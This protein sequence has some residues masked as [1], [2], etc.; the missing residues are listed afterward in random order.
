MSIKIVRHSEIG[1]LI[2]N[3]IIRNRTEQDEHLQKILAKRNYTT[4]AHFIKIK[5]LEHRV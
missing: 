4:W 3:R 2:R 5:K 1:H